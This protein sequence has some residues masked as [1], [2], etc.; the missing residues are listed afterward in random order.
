[1]LPADATAASPDAALVHR[2]KAGDEDAY[3]EI[4]RTLGG[5]MLGV[6]RRFLHDEELG[7]DALQ[8]AVPCPPR[9]PPPPAPRGAPPAVSST[10]RS[11]PV[12]PS[13]TRSCPPSAPSTRSTAT[14]RSR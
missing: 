14:P 13:R 11:W 1:M 9:R 8:D 4:V 10:T 12:T 7:R 2:L 5:R 3:G 6:A